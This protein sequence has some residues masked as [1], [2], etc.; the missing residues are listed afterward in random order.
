MASSQWTPPNDVGSPSCS[1]VSSPIADTHERAVV[2]RLVTAT[3]YCDRSPP[4]P[5]AP[6][7][8]TIRS[9]TMMIDPGGAD[10]VRTEDD[11]G[12]IDTSRS[13]LAQLGLSGWDAAALGA[14]GL[15][16]MLFAPPLFLESWTPRMALVLAFGPVGLVALARFARSGDRSSQLLVGALI[17]TVFISVVGPASRSSLFGFAGRDLSALTVA[18]SAGFW[19]LGRLMSDRGRQLL[20]DVIV[21]AAALSGAIGIAQVLAEVDSGSLALA[22]GRPTGLASNPVYFGAVSAAGLT[23]CIAS[24]TA[25][26]WKRYVAPLVVLGA[27]TSLSGSRVALLAAVLAIVAHTIAR[28]DRVASV[29]G[30][31]GIM[32]L[33]AGVALDRVAG[34]GRNAADRLAESSGGGRSTVWRYGL[35]AFTERPVLGYGFGRFRSAVQ[36]KFSVDFVRDYSIDEVT[37]AWFDPHNVGI[38]VL[39]AVGIVGTALFLAWTLSWIPALRGPLAWALLP[40][41]LHWLL[42]PVSL[43]TLPLAMLLFG[44]AGTMRSV[45]NPPGRRA[46]MAAATFGVALAGTLVVGDFVFQRAADELD[47]DTMAAVASAAGDD[48]ILGDVVA[49]AYELEAPSPEGSS[50]ALDWRR[51]VAESEPDR[52]FWWSQLAREAVGGRPGG[53]CGAVDPHGVGAPTKQHAVAS[54]RDPAG[55]SSRGRGTSVRRARIDVRPRPERLRHRCRRAHRRVSGVHG[56]WRLISDGT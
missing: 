41:A 23:V 53:R 45:E 44:A 12:R 5:M 32:S 37:Q 18:T 24:W 1:A 14:A 43:F 33:A 25:T 31:V 34:A 11:D 22:S 17:W 4:V 3:S 52:P 27:A 29:A 26:T 19:M 55:D 6:S 36:D 20:C 30:G 39:V 51:R 38:G 46:T 48:P 15:A 7:P 35:D 56:R 16:I 2:S 10:D 21:W 40:L 13:T 49:R 50:D 54:C 47:A 42:Q 8:D 9:A 28:R